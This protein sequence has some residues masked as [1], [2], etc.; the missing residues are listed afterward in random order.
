MAR[1]KRGPFFLSLKIKVENP[2]PSTSLRFA[3]DDKSMGT[4]A[5][6]M[7]T[8]TRYT[9]LE[10]STRRYLHGEFQLFF[11]HHWN[12]HGAVER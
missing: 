1:E 5:L 6:G 7:T 12:T 2:D 3:R 4:R 9:V 11:F 10:L 8:Q